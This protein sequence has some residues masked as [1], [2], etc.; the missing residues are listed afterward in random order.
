[1]VNKISIGIFAV[2][3]AASVSGCSSLVPGDDDFSCPGGANIIRC[4]SARQI[5]DMTTGRDD[6][7]ALDGTTERPDGDPDKGIVMMP[8]NAEPR[9]VVPT[10]VTADYGRVPVRTPAK[11][12]RI[13][14]GPWE[15]ED[16]DLAV[17]GL[18]YVEIEPKRWQI[19]QAAGEGNTK[20]FTPLS[21]NSFNTKPD[22]TPSADGP[23]TTPAPRPGTLNAKPP[24]NSGGT[25]PVLAAPMVQAVTSPSLTATQQ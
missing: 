10:P 11:I 5:Y 14:V 24:V 6:L 20:S 2:L 18:L 7:S 25:K 3:L 17:G 9:P 1:M 15:T 23:G 16:G 12:M 8:M 13:W 22:A 21:G 4:K 19:G